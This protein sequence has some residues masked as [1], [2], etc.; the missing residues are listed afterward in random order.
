MGE[1]VPLQQGD[2]QAPARGVQCHP[3][4]G[5]AAADHDDVDHVAGGERV[6]LH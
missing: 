5:D 2:R 1:V 4:A 3:G 6:Q